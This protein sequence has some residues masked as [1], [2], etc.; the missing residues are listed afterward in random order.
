MKSEKSNWIWDNLKMQL[1]SLNK[2]RN[3]SMTF[4]G[5]KVEVR[6]WFNDKETLLIGKFDNKKDAELFMEG[7]K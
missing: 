1:I 2:V 5:D 7:L 6:A 4:Q 3:I